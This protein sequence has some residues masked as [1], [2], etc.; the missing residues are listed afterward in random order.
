MTSG[1]VVGGAGCAE[2]GCI[3]TGWRPAGA[4]ATTTLPP[5]VES[6][7]AGDAALGAGLAAAFGA[8]FGAAFE[9][10][11]AGGAAARRRAFDRAES[12]AAARRR[13]TAGDVV[14][15][16]SSDA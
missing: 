8:G 16:E 3:G 10:T 7:S 15:V 4:P 5:P 6:L 9:A 12:A 2:A 13:S 14:R 11:R 1:F